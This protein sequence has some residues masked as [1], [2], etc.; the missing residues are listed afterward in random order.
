MICRPLFVTRKFPPSVGGMETLSAGVW[1]TLDAASDAQLLAHRGSNRWLALWLPAAAARTAWR[2]VR[3]RPDVV[4]CGDA[5]VHATLS[6]IL[7]LLRVS[8]ATMVM[9]LDITYDRPLYRH[10]VVRLLRRAPRVLA[11]S[12]ATAAAA[13]AMGVPAERAVVVRLGVEVPDV[14]ADDRARARAAVLQ[15]W[16]LPEDATLLLTLGRLVRRKGALWFTENVVPATS[17]RA[18]YLVAGTG[19]DAAAIE[20]AAAANHVGLRVHLLGQVTTEERE[21]LLRG[22]DLFIQANVPVPGD[23]EGFGLV[24]VEAAVRGT[25]VLASGIEGIRDAVIE[26]GTGTLVPAA[27]VDRWIEAVEVALADPEVL[28]EQGRRAR[29]VASAEYSEAAMGRALLARLEG[30]RG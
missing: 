9:G 18:H 25:P 28:A 10:T 22:S 17:P 20:A 2:V 6:P 16:G 19:P 23:M 24:T 30:L 4:L 26:G 27:D 1:R 13:V 5:V 29:E 3:H 15:R 7:R 21:E 8:H 14:D 11:I 12:E